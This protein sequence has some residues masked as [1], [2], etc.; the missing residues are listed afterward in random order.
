MYSCYDGHYDFGFCGKEL[1]FSGM[2]QY[3]WERS[4]FQRLQRLVK[5]SGLPAG[6][7]GQVQTDY[8]A[9]IYGLFR[10]G[11]LCVFETKKW[12]VTFQPATPW[13]LGLQFQPTGM[14]VATPYFNFTRPLEVGRECSVIKLTPDYMGIWDI[15]SKYATE[16]TYAEIA[17][18]QSMLNARFAYVI[19]AEDERTRRS[20]NAL[21]EKLQNGEPGIVYDV[22]MRKR[23]K[24][25]GIEDT[26]PWEQFDR[27]LKQNFILP[28]LLEARRT[29]ITDF[30]REIGVP[31]PQDKKER[32]NVEETKMIDAETF[33]RR[34]V[35]KQCLTESL[36]V[37]NRMFG[38]NITFDMP[39]MEEEVTEDDIQKTPDEPNRK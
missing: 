19:A 31:I 1:T 2:C 38:L 4:L 37:T 14:N 13:G 10:M 9:F 35:W 26:L 18:R 16:L 39:Q 25:D 29:I 17:V 33:T 20:A 7:K 22:S 3:Y 11:F 5:F 27:D 34:E 12:G 15:V 32:V 24:K 36:D 28:E 8:D 21:M 6:G 23:I 30:Y